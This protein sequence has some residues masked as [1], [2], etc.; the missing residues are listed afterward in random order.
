LTNFG[1]I[2]KINAESACKAHGLRPVGFV[3]VDTLVADRSP[4]DKSEKH[5]MRRMLVCALAVSLL[6]VSS[7]CPRKKTAPGELSYIP[8]DAAVVAVVRVKRI[9]EAKLLEPLLQDAMVAAQLKQSPIDLRKIESAT[10]AG[11]PRK[12]EAK[13]WQPPFSPVAVIR[14]T[15]PTDAKA[16][17]EKIAPPGR[18]KF[19]ERSHQG[20]TYYMAERDNFFFQ[21]DE[22]TLVIGE[23]EETVKG[24]LSGAANG[25]AA[26]KLQAA[27]AGDDLVAV[28]LME[29]MQRFVQEAKGK[30]DKDAPPPLAAMAALTDQL[31]SGTLTVN[32]SGD[33]LAKLVLDCTSAEAGK[34][35]GDALKGALEFGKFMAGMAIA[36][37][38]ASKETPP[39]AKQALDVAARTLGGLQLTQSGEQVVLT[40]AKPEGLEK[41][42]ASIPELMRQRMS[43]GPGLKRPTRG[44]KTSAPAFKPPTQDE[45]AKPEPSPK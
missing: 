5:V 32:L 28:V 7:G 36:G 11:V 1:G 18:V 16:M 40:A 30:L 3:W 21:P 33:T 38:Q 14:F 4:P 29:P 24:L 13:P 43:A 6:L 15:E 19:E 9:M 25:P 39:E 26:E 10:V 2:V 8:P 34:K 12:G 31:K 23:L 22:K 17:I 20:K 41:L 37:A 44:G 45:P 35:V 27:G 42:V